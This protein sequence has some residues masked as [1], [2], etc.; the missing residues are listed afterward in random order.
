MV[1]GKASL[2]NY[3]DLTTQNNMGA[4]LVLGAE[5]HGHNYAEWLQIV[6]CSSYQPQLIASRELSSRKLPLP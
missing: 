6:S 5:M 2:H 1:L 4:K 3:S